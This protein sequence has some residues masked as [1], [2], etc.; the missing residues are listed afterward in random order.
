MSRPS[1]GDTERGQARSLRSETQTGRKEAKNESDEI[2]IEDPAVDHFVANS[3]D[4]ARMESNEGVTEAGE[5]RC[6]A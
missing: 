4:S 3:A 6:A 5:T 1:G 2:N